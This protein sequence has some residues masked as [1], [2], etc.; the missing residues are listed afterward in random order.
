MSA[1]WAR[2]MLSIIFN[3]PGR[4]RGGDLN[5]VFARACQLALSKVTANDCCR[6]RRAA[7]PT[8]SDGKVKDDGIS[9]KNNA[10][11]NDSAPCPLPRI[12]SSSSL[13]SPASLRGAKLRGVCQAEVVEDAPIIR[14]SAQ[15]RA[16]LQ[17]MPISPLLDFLFFFPRWRLPLILTTVPRDETAALLWT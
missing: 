3:K 12:L 6:L 8:V 15:S 13:S 17:G 4:I 2:C 10:P 9:F 1:T 11:E 14:Q 7:V 5:A 16:Y